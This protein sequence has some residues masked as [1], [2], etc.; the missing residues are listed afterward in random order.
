MLHQQ[1]ISVSVIDISEKASQPAD[2]FTSRLYETSN[3]MKLIKVVHEPAISSKT[4][5]AVQ[6]ADMQT[7]VPERE[8]ERERERHPPSGDTRTLATYR[9]PL[10]TVVLAIFLSII[11]SFLSFSQAPCVDCR[12][13]FS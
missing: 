8:R 7:A 6:R 12:V 11:F 10:S 2:P 4:V 9:R 3:W 5:S 13:R 1:R